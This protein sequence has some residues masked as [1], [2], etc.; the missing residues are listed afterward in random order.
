MAK[1]AA[2]AIM[3]AKR[4]PLGN[5]PSVTRIKQAVFVAYDFPLMLKAMIIIS[6]RC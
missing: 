2:Y 5:A 6:M 4:F 3:E 1:P